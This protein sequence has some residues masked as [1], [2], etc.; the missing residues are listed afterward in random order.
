MDLIV[1]DFF[2]LFGIKNLC[3]TLT[4]AVCIGKCLINEVFPVSVT[5]P[6]VRRKIDGEK[7]WTD[8]EAFTAALLSVENIKSSR[9]KCVYASGACFD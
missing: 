1:T 3:F 4:N 8:K 6:L 7:T 5:A 2:F 9:L